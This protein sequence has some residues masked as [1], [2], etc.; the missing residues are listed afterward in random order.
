MRN[1]EPPRTAGSSSTACRFLRGKLTITADPREGM[2]CTLD[3]KVVRQPKVVA[4]ETSG[5][6]DE[7]YLVEVRGVGQGDV[8]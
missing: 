2:L 7:I 3:G 4:D 5:E 8:E 1:Y 6:I